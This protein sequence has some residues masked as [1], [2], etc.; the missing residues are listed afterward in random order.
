MQAYTIIVA[1]ILATILTRFIPFWIIKDKHLD[2]P[3]LLS[4]SKFLPSASISLLLV[5]VYRS[6]ST[7]NSNFFPTI[8]ASLCVV[9]LHLIFK[10]SLISIVLGTI[11]YM[12]FI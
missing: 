5:Y 3:I 6:L 2:H 8:L 11:V 1:G 10:K 9:F 4:L 7:T 12:L